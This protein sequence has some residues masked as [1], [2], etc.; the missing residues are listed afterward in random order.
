MKK[1]LFFCVLSAFLLCGCT[2]T[3]TPDPG[4]GPGP[5]PDPEPNKYTIIFKN[6]D[7]TVLQTLTDVVEG[8]V[9]TYTGST[10]TK[11]EDD[12]YIYTFANWTPAV[13]AAY[14]NAV[15]T[16]TYSSTEKS[17]VTD[18]GKKTIAEVI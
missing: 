11:P 8:T 16:A 2:N 17:K 4:P 13:V 3:P 6:Y 12:D 14:S 1:K 10:P 15:Y 7:D 9:P 18:L 5:G